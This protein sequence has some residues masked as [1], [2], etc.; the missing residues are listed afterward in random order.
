DAHAVLVHHESMTRGKTGYDP[1]PQDTRLFITRWHKFLQR[2]DPCYTPLMNLYRHDMALNPHAR[3]PNALSART[4]HLALA[5]P[6]TATECTEAAAPGISARF[7][8]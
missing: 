3:S 8:A 6:I 5:R 7:A 1:H 4:V 2:G